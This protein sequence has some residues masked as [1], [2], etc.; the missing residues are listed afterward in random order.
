LQLIFFYLTGKIFYQKNDL[1][2]V[3]FISFSIYVLTV[4]FYITAVFG[5]SITSVR[6]HILSLIDKNGKQGISY[7]KILEDYNRENIVSTRLER[8][9]GSKVLGKKNGKYFLFDKLSP[10]LI[11]LKYC[12]LLMKIYSK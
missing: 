5:I 12:D 3:F 2:E 4:Y 9:V 8:L 10:F 1:L 6:I 11:N 7:K